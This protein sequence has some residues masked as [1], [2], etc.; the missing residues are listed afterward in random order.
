MATRKLRTLA[1]ARK[2][3]DTQGA[4]VTALTQEVVNLKERIKELEHQGKS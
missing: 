2:I 1:E 4:R 3:I